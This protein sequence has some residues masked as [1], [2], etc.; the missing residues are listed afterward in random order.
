MC[1]SRCGPVRAYPVSYPYIADP[2]SS[3]AY[4]SA[5]A[6]QYFRATRELVVADLPDL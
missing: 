2:D 3:I 5:G 1:K 6:V 4:L